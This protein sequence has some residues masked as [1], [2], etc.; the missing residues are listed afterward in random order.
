M[1]LIIEDFMKDNGAHFS[2]TTTPDRVHVVID[3]NIITGQNEQSTLLAANNLLLQAS[4]LR[5]VDLVHITNLLL[6]THH[7]RWLNGIYLILG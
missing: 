2:A 5:Y 6:S 4:H 1:T 7:V 3:G